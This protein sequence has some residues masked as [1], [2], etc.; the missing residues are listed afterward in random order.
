MKRGNKAPLEADDVFSLPKSKQSHNAWAEFEPVWRRAAQKARDSHKPIGSWTLLWCIIRCC[1]RSWLWSYVCAVVGQVLQLFVPF[2]LSD[3]VAYLQD[4]SGPVWM[5]V[6]YVVAII[7]VTMLTSVLTFY[8]MYLTQA[9]SIN[10]CF[11]DILKTLFI[12]LLSHHPLQQIRHELQLLV[13]K[14][15]LKMRAADIPDQGRCVNLISV[16]AQSFLDHITYFNAALAT[17]FFLFCLFHESFFAL[18]LA[19]FT[20]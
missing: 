9:L 3:V 8:S 15:T 20:F 16:D 13:Y 18:T 11:P 12:E 1:W 10:V 6:V 14:K 17:P 19:I 5:G 7:G 4:P 2:I